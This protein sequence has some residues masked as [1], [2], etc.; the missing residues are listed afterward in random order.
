LNIESFIRQ[1]ADKCVKCGLCLPHC[2]TYMKTQH[3]GDSPRGRI[4]L[5]QGLVEGQLQFSPQ[6]EAHLDSCLSCR[7]CEHACP[8]TVQYGQLLDAGRAHI[9]EH[10]HGADSH[11][12]LDR[13][14]NHAQPLGIPPL[15]LRLYQTT[16]LQWIARRS[17][18]LKKLGLQRLDQYLPR[19]PRHV[20]WR[21]EYPSQGKCRGSVALFTGCA[22]NLFDQATLQA[23][24]R[25]LT[26][27]GYKVHI[28]PEQVCCGAMHQHN[29]NIEQACQFA[30]S[31]LK[32]FNSLSADALIYTATGCGTT[33]N[34]Y[35]TL[36]RQAFDM[37][38]MD[39]SRFFEQISWPDEITVEPL[40]KKVAVH[41][42]CTLTHV[43]GS[44]ASVYALLAKI[45]GLQL[46]A[47]P[48]NATCCGAAGSYMLTQ[49][50]MA[51]ALLSD[52][53]KLLE[54]LQPDILLTSNIGCALHLV[55][56]IREAGLKIEVIHPVALLE[57]QIKSDK[58]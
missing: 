1:E 22:S 33:L 7:A 56:G 10:H 35:Q 6:L 25:L 4:A 48:D 20:K 38:V 11:S 54:T 23:T 19:I 34:E 24:I 58:R 46:T 21:R 2:P 26:R 32:V 9:A 31:N 27:C 16:G 53:I 44:E 51:D 49:P 40:D 18:L 5:L 52:K 50:V 14:S 39:V 47:L 36:A 13:L 45:P 43:L 41:D 28:P 42:P 30:N 3:E 12:L 37:P 57:R 29:G 55:A 8:A 17:G 15:L